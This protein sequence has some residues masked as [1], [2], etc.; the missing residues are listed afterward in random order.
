MLA[1][2]AS[3]LLHAVDAP[4]DQSGCT[5]TN[6][7]S[8][9]WQQ[10]KKR[11]SQF[12]DRCVA[13]AGYYYQ[14]QLFEDVPGYYRFWQSRFSSRI[15]DG[16]LG[17]YAGAH[18]KRSWKDSPRQALIIGT[19]RSCDRALREV[20][21]AEKEHR[22]KR[23]KAGDDD[24]IVI[25]MMG[26]YC[27][28]IPGF[29]I[30]NARFEFGEGVEWKRSVGNVARKTYG[31]LQR[32][33][34]LF[35]P[36]KRELR[37]IARFERAVREGDWVWIEKTNLANKFSHLRKSDDPSKREL[38][39]RFFRGKLIDFSNEEF[40]KNDRQFFKS[41]HGEYPDDPGSWFSCY[42]T[43][44]DCEGVWPISSLDADAKPE[45]PYLCIELAPSLDEP[46]EIY[47]D[48]KPDL[49]LPE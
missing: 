46:G 14:G 43:N 25:V 42:C 41:R 13:V 19:L 5:R 12:A 44:D 1:T 48:L 21:A 26:G 16:W 10:I 49:G 35:Q 17:I 18:V 7:V 29:A 33:F 47:L 31:D 40:I 9:T 32:A 28:S 4:A 15:N 3:L 24:A 6:S 39:E 8:V 22:K 23:R 30:F 45:R 27:H 2:L 37:L 11:P 36:P 34:G 20:L 38:L